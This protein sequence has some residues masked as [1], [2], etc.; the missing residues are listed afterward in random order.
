MRADVTLAISVVL[1]AKDEAEN[2]P[3]L[4]QEIEDALIDRAFEVIVVDDG[5]TDR[6]APVVLEFA[7]RH[8][9]ARLISHAASCGQSAA[10]RTGLLAARGEIVVT[11]DGDGQNDPRYIPALLDALAAGGPGIA[12]AAGERLGRKASFGKRIASRLANRLRRAMLDDRSRDTGCGLK[13]IR[14]EVFLKLP[15]FDGWHRFLPA[16]VLR[17]G[18]GIR[19][20]DVVDRPRRHGKSKY[21][22]FDRAMVAGV[23]LLGVWWLRRR[24]RRRPVATERTPHGT[25]DASHLTER[26]HP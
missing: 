21:G 8:P 5:S 19:Q 17:E 24:L 18:F 3:F 15:Y 23:D 11:I 13:A 7:R 16:L 14:R 26:S 6:T 12:I 2:L 1:P 4:L 20:V 9:W 10:V 22:I 25:A